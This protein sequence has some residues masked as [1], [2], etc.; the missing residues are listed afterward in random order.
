M[1]KRTAEILFQ[2]SK[3]QLHRIGLFS[4]LLQ[5]SNISLNIYCFTSYKSSKNIKSQI[6][7]FSNYV[8]EVERTV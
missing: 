5:L 1:I 4:T 8:F 7:I 2:F 3:I 6:L